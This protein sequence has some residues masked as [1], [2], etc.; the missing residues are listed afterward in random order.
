MSEPNLNWT[1][2]EVGVR[3]QA[4]PSRTLT[5]LTELGEPLQTLYKIIKMSAAAVSDQ[6]ALYLVT[7]KPSEIP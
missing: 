5:N 4:L 1:L 6:L 2:A 3:G 7:I